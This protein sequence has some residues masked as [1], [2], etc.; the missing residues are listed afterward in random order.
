M[1]HNLLLLLGIHDSLTNKTV[2]NSVHGQESEIH[3]E[4]A[5]FLKFLSQVHEFH[6]PINPPPKAR[7]RG[8]ERERWKKDTERERDKKREREGGEKRGLRM[9]CQSLLLHVL[10]ASLL[11]IQHRHRVHHLNKNTFNNSFRNSHLDQDPKFRNQSQR[12]GTQP[13]PEHSFHRVSHS[14]NT[15]KFREKK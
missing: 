3:T 9:E 15:S 2:Q 8:R 7:E 6:Q 10:R 13:K 11:T 14:P 5:L 1:L 4:Y 12:R